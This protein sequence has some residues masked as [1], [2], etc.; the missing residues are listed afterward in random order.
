MKRVIYLLTFFMFLGS[1]SVSA[2][3]YKIEVKIK[4]AENSQLILGHHK[5]ENLIPDDTTQTDTKGYGVFTG[6]TLTGGMYFIFLN[7]TYFDFFVA[8]DQ[9]FYLETD[10]TDYLKNLKFTGSD[11]NTLFIEYQAFLQNQTKKLG[12]LK[13][14]KDAETN[15]AKKAELTKQIDNLSTEFYA[16]YDK[17]QAAYPNYF[18]TKFLKATKQ[19]EVPS[20]I[21]D[22][23]QQYYYYRFHYFDNFDLSD[24][25][26]LHTPLYEEKVTNFMDNVLINHPDTLIKE[27]DILLAK[28]EK[29][30]ELYKY[31][32]IYLFNKYAKSQLMAAE[33]V[34]T[35]LG[36]EYIK[37]ATWDTDS[38]K[39]QLKPKLDK[40]SNCLV[41]NKALN[42]T[43]QLL[44]T[45]SVK[46]EKIRSQIP[47]INAKGMVIEK[48]TS[49]TF[50]QKMPDLV[51]LISEFMGNFPG[52]TKLHDTKAKYTILWF[53]E[54]DCSH[55]KKET[56]LFY[57]E[58]IS[59]LKKYDVT[60][61]CFYMQ[62]DI[63]DW[64]NFTN[65]IN[66]WFDFVETNKF[67]EWNNVWNP[68]DLYR[69][70][71]DISSSP[72]LYLLDAD[73]KIIGKRI[74]WEQCSEM[75]LALEGVVKE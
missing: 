67:Y 51:D 61:F 53:F 19:I 68:F 26:L 33:N 41:G 15:E 17:I 50:Q 70:N 32:M 4:G 66:H 57:E 37:K 12:D 5:N 52:Y 72:V 20:T 71:Y 14:L 28:T 42:V 75:I 46:I 23:T 64:T 31:M 65:S 7:G 69:D 59:K 24:I 8:D 13:T 39:I 1:F 44:P 21:T 62:R 16:Y 49:K 18:F 25:R 35:H 10:T 56:P 58:Y 45:D 22:Q 3:T 74:G 40:K 11:E 60:V 54:P 55:C 43:M 6:S 36:Y 47:E 48:N 73:K 63:D 9:V 34:Y 27:C 29:N 30:P 38:F 2:Q